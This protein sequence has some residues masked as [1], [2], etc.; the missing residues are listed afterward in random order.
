M[1]LYN[2]KEKR[3]NLVEGVSDTLKDATL[4]SF[5]GESPN[6]NFEP[7]VYGRLFQQIIFDTLSKI[8]DMQESLK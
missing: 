8:C 1:M 2:E 4:H 3:L 5:L 7:H 6:S